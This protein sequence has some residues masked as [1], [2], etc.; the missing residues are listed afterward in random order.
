MLWVKDGLL[1][2]RD[3]AILNC[4]S[5]PPCGSTGTGT[6]LECVFSPGELPT[7]LTA[8]FV[9]T[10]TCPGGSPSASIL[11]GLTDSVHGEYDVAIGNSALCSFLVI[12]M[13]CFVGEGFVFGVTLTPAVGPACC[14]VSVPVTVTSLSPFSGN[15]VVDLTGCPV[16]VNSLCGDCKKW[17]VSITE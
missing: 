3:G 5:C 13:S 4:D 12:G 8:H 14:I 16:C 11:M 1:L 9:P 17:N 10:G 2:M 7:S 15:C 6:I